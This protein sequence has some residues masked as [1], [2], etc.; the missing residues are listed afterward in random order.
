MAC[1]EGSINSCKQCNNNI[2]VAVARVTGKINSS[3]SLQLLTDGH[4]G[5]LPKEQVSY[6]PEKSAKA[7]SSL[8]DKLF[9]DRK[10]SLTPF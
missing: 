8:E 9:K 2:P 6:I 10:H 5:T 3:S 4:P 7:Y 1:G